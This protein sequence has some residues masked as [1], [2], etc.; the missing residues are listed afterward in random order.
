[1]KKEANIVFYKE[2]LYKYL[3]NERV[4]LVNFFGEVREEN[5]KLVLVNVPQCKLDK[6][7]YTDLLNNLKERLVLTLQEVG[8]EKS[9]FS[10]TDFESRGLT[11]GNYNILLKLEEIPIFI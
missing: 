3:S 1:M 9:F 8:A 6:I 5:G 2:K 11:N 4:F 10:V 7:Q